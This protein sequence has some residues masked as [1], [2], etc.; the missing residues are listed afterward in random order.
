LVIKTD[1]FD[2]APAAILS[3]VKSN[4]EIHPVTYLSQTFSDT[5]LNYDTH[6][7][8]LMAIYEAFKAW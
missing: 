8:E 3:Q 7:K 4:G 1:A 5:E 6:D 2:Y